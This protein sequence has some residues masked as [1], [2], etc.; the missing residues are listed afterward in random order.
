MVFFNFNFIL[1]RIL[2]CKT[3]E[4]MTGVGFLYL[5]HILKFYFIILF[6]YLQGIAK[7]TLA[8]I[9]SAHEEALLMIICKGDLSLD[10]TQGDMPI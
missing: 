9:W 8:K 7:S 1:F 5:V 6:L 10:L 3:Q 2:G 4:K